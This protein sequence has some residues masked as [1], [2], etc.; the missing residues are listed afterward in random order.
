MW[1]PISSQLYQT[2]DSI[3]LLSHGRALYS[4]PGG[5]APARHFSSQGIAYQEGYNVAD[6][7]LDVASDPPVSIFPMSTPDPANLSSS[8]T[9][10]LGAS[11]EGVIEDEKL[12][13]RNATPG[14]SGSLEQVEAYHPHPLS[15]GNGTLNNQRPQSGYAATF[16]TQF[17][18]LSG[19]EWKIL[20]RYE[21]R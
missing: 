7:L 11:K 18:V 2:F 13:H 15:T 3:L 16:L 20:R 21:G 14:G 10:K 12:G 4:G 17:E 9:P 8:V 6:Y 1:R 19:R 5:F